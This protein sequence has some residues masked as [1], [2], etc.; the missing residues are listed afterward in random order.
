MFV[1]PTEAQ[2]KILKTL[3]NYLSDS[4]NIIQKINKKTYLIS[5]YSHPFRLE[6]EK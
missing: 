1:N 2:G 5:F 6:S 3:L 4:D